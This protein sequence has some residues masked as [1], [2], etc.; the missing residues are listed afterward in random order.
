MIVYLVLIH[1]ID[2]SRWIQVD[3]ALLQ[4]VVVFVHAGGGGPVGVTTDHLVLL[5]LLQTILLLAFELE[6]LDLVLHESGE[7]E[8]G[9]VGL[10]LAAGTLD[11][12]AHIVVHDI[13]RV[14]LGIV[15]L[16][17]VSIDLVDAHFAEYFGAIVAHFG[18]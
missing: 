14:L 17:Y 3:V 6:I 4:H 11:V 1:A 10:L 2:A 7:A 5:A 16:A 18:W 13:R 12:L 8:L 9:P 15:N